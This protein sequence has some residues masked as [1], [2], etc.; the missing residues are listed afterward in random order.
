MLRP[1]RAACLKG[2][3]PRQKIRSLT[4]QEYNE[5]SLVEEI[6]FWYS[7][8]MADQAFLKKDHASKST[9]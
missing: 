2:R 7:Q 8:M 1:F 6:N 4:K 5:N 3:K 9:I